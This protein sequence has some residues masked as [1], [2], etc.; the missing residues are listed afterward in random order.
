[1]VC[2]PVCTATTRFLVGPSKL[3]CFP[4]YT[5]FTLPYSFS[6]QNVCVFNSLTEVLRSHFKNFAMLTGSEV[7]CSLIP[8]QRRGGRGIFSV[9]DLCDLSVYEISRI[10][11]SICSV[12][13]FLDQVFS[14]FFSMDNL[15]VYGEDD[16]VSSSGLGRSSTKLP[17]SSEGLPV[18]TSSQASVMAASTPATTLVTSGPVPAVSA[19]TTPAS[20]VHKD[21]TVAL[22]DLPPPPPPAEPYEV[23]L[24][25]V[26][27][28][29]SSL[30][31]RSAQLGAAV[32]PHPVVATSTTGSRL[33]TPFPRYEDSS[34]ALQPQAP[35]GRIRMPLPASCYAPPPSP[36]VWPGRGPAVDVTMI[37]GPL[38]T[39]LPTGPPGLPG[40]SVLPAGPPAVGPAPVPPS[41]PSTELKKKKNTSPPSPLCFRGFFP[42]ATPPFIPTAS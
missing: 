25:R 17:P 33:P 20:S 36:W 40:P 23:F 34:W 39:T 37:R 31:V 3:L 38:P 18:P 14:C 41:T 19:L 13:P 32:P 27:R 1:M 8:S 21:C 11:L 15:R 9:Q 2:R 7:L 28:E 24:A 42:G 6:H 5:T 10:L 12:T 29:L 4:T 30:P 26:S 22:D 35:G 16:A